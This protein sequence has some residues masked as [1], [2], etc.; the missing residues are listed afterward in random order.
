MLEAFALAVSLLAFACSASTPDE[1]AGPSVELVWER[2]GTGEIRLDGRALGALAA[3][4]A[5]WRL[6]GDAVSAR[7]SVDERPL[8]DAHPFPKRVRIEG[9]LDGVAG[10]IRYEYTLLAPAAPLPVEGYGLVVGDDPPGTNDEE[11]EAIRAWLRA[12]GLPPDTRPFEAIHERETGRELR[13][14]YEISG[15]RVDGSVSRVGAAEPAARLDALFRSEAGALKIHHK[16]PGENGRFTY[17]RRSLELAERIAAAGQPAL[18]LHECGCYGYAIASDLATLGSALYH[19]E[20]DWLDDR[21]GAGFFVGLEARRSFPWLGIGER[22]RMRD[23]ARRARA[24]LLKDAHGTPF[25]ELALELPADPPRGS[26]GAIR[27]RVDEIGADAA[28]RPLARVSHAPER[29]TLELFG[30]A[31]GW[32]A[33][34]ERLDALL[35]AL[36]VQVRRGDGIRDSQLGEIERLVDAVRLLEAPDESRLADFVVDVDATTA[37]RKV[38]GL[39]APE[40]ARFQPAGVALP[41]D[42][43]PGPGRETSHARG[44]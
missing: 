24:Y 17:H 32:E 14:W 39:L 16:R 2:N 25:A 36:P 30:P 1:P 35:A 13:V 26:L 41:P 34:L 8:G 44:S 28:R 21:V 43:I 23:L 37:S 18:T 22:R 29:I 6:R 10:A 20:A 19:V 4:G 5:E 42:P 3:D 33:S 9:R 27:Y 40:L 11:H 31:V 7:S 12:Q 38:A 15:R